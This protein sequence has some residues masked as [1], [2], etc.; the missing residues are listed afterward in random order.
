MKP[1]TITGAHF[2]RTSKYIQVTGTLDQPGIGL[3]ADDAGGELDP[4]GADLF[5]NPLGS[6]V[7]STG[8]PSGDN[9]TYG[10]AFEWN[11]FVGT[12]KFCIKLCDPNQGPDNYCEKWAKYV[13]ALCVC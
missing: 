1:G 9:K 13:L 8:L 10:Q 7:Y 6:L 3:T 4:H 5:G 12:G 2:I 11:N